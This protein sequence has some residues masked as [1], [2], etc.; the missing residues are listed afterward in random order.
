MNWDDTPG[1]LPIYWIQVG[2]RVFHRNDLMRRALELER[3]PEAEIPRLDLTLTVGTTPASGVAPPG[4]PCYIAVPKT[5]EDSSGSGTLSSTM[6][7]STTNYPTPKSTLA[8]AG[9]QQSDQAVVQPNR[10]A[11]CAGLCWAL[12]LVFRE[13]RSQDYLLD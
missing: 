8:Q 12:S 9:S 2:S 3:W 5:A 6:P 13:H 10:R 7:T 11:G 1:G 4:V